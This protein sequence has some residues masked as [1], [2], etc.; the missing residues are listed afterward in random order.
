MMIFIIVICVVFIVLCLMVGL[1]ACH[2]IAGM[3]DDII[4]KQFDEERSIESADIFIEDIGEEK[5]DEI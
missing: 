1:C 4:T 2:R 5:D 3:E